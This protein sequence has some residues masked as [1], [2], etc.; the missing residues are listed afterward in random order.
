MSNLVCQF[1]GSPRFFLDGSM[2]KPD[3][4]KA[5]ALAA[6]L[7]V[8]GR[9]VLRERLAD[10]FWPDYSRHSAL[11]SL[12]R[13]L[14]AM[15]KVLGKF[16]INADRQTICFV[17]GKAV[18]VD[19]LTF[20]DL[21]RR[22]GVDGDRFNK[23]SGSLHDL[24]RAAK[25]YNGPFLSGFS[26]L[27]A[28]DFDDWQFARKEELE[29]DY[30]RTLQTLA[31]TYEKQGND[32]AAMAHAWAW[33]EHDALNEAAHRCLI[34]LYGRSGQKN[35]VQQQ[36]EKCADLLDAE[37]GINPDPETSRLADRF[38][39]LNPHSVEKSPPQPDDLPLQSITFI[40]RHQELDQIAGRLFRTDARLLTLTGPGGMGKTRLALEAMTRPGL[41]PLSMRAFFVPLA[42]VPSLDDMRTH[43]LKILGLGQ[44]PGPDQAADPRK[45][46][47]DF[48][49]TRKIVLVMDNL[50]HLPGI[51][52]E[53]AH[54]L[55]NTRH[56]KILATGRTRLGLSIEQVLVLSGLACH[57]AEPGIEVQ[58][59]PDLV[60]SDAARLFLVSFG[61]VQP[62]VKPGAQ[63]AHDIIRICR[64]TSAIPLALILAGGWGDVFSLKDI[65]DKVEQSIDFLTADDPDLLPAHKSMRSVFET[66]WDCLNQKEKDL[67]MRL[68]VFSGLFSRQAAQAVAGP[69]KHHPGRC[70][71]S[72]IVRK[73]LVKMNPGTGLFELHA[74]IRR[75]AKEKLCAAGVLEKTLDKHERYYLDLARR[76]E[77]ELIGPQMQAYRTD[78]DRAFANIEQAW[79]RALSRGNIAA[80]SQCAVG[81]YI[82]FDMHTRYLGGERFF[83]DAQTFIADPDR[84]FCPR[85]G[86]LLMCWFDMQN[87]SINNLK[88]LEPIRAFAWKW[89]KWSVKS[90]DTLSRARAL[91]FLG[92]VAQKKKEYAR[93]ARLYRLSL[94]QDPGVERAFWV[95]MRMGLCLRARGL[96]GQALDCFEK[97]IGIGRDFKDTTKIAWALGNAGFAHLCLGNIES[98]THKLLAAKD[99][100]TQIKALLGKRFC[101]EEL[102][103]IALFQ[104]RFDQALELADQAAVL[105]YDAG[106]DL[107]Y[108][109]RA[110]ALKGMALLMKN[111]AAQARTCFQ[112]IENTGI[113]G[114]TAC[115]GM[116]FIAVLNNTPLEAA[117]YEKKAEHLAASVNKPQFISL[118]YLLKAAVLFLNKDN[119]PAAGMLN[120]ALEHPFC[121]KG[122]FDAWPFVGVLTGQFMDKA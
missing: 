45:Q 66:S 114:F 117:F 48:L 50:E 95:T 89:L 67:F 87:Q 80:V 52:T 40:G 75:F 22:G 6:F 99:R 59:L 24:E 122:L 70:V 81:L 28:P 11:A 10:L 115:V 29:R 82:Y 86:V 54:M 108:H 39:A 20:Q 26:L 77:K 57:K 25:T 74:L 102:G 62:D 35:R 98:A 118:L 107:F 23:N 97:S 104:G 100:F 31:Q 69:F 112:E 53:I 85:A 13:T 96:M 94:V 19:V 76:G 92:A 65:A 101:L 47:L 91:V 51:E 78:M 103:L 18:E 38:L 44:G 105:S 15:G 30:I 21:V 79:K 106:E 63:N 5:V 110:T 3:R 120:Q 2:V 90:G 71:F 12:R 73:S 113:L 111:D 1:L 93:A 46:I 34:R 55:D 16:W 109:Q 27:D 119:A 83:R 9:P 84:L 60:R 41:L 43:L 116:G 42:N 33:A 7:T 49:G 72:N 37:L 61:R 36:F 8:H 58:M 88:S 32:K 68:S 121:P 4:R 64:A 17:P 56:L 14:S